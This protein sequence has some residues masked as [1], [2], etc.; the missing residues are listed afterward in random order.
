MNRYATEK[1]QKWLHDII[2]VGIVFTVV[3]V[4]FHF[5]IGVAFIKGNSMFPTLQNNDIAVY[6]RIIP[7]FKPGDVLSIRMPSGEYY[8]KRAIAMEGDIVDIRKGIVYINDVP[9]KEPYAYGVTKVKENG[10]E[11]PYQVEKGKVFV[12]GDNREESID[13]RDF[14]VV[15]QQRVKGKIWFRI[16][17]V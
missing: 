8:V 5:V 13:S 14:G 1:W 17:K 3:F 6:T 12:L 7:R 9:L 16:G 10:I 2:R 4:M 15:L 11:F